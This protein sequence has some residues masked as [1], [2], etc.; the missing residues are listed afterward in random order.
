M[1]VKIQLME[2]SKKNATFRGR[3]ENYYHEH[4]TFDSDHNWSSLKQM[5][6]CSM[7]VFCLVKFIHHR[8]DYFIMPVFCLVNC[9]D[10]TVLLWLLE[11]TN[12]EHE[13]DGNEEDEE[14]AKQALAGALST[15]QVRCGRD[16]NKF[17]RGCFTEVDE[18]GDPTQPPISV[19]V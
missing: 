15:S 19:N 16:L 10:S 5:H 2:T 13:G 17:S 3:A 4:R 14:N 7:S 6:E 11:A 9:H 8:A 18:V 12:V 1:L